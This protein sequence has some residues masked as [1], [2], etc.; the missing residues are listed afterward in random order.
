MILMLMRYDRM[1]RSMRWLPIGLAMG[2]FLLA[3]KGTPP[4]RHPGVRT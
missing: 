3:L 2:A 4:S 1:L